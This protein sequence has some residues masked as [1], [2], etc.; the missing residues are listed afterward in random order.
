M[1]SPHS[2][3]AT[4][5]SELRAMLTSE[6]TLE[7]MLEGV[8]DLTI[9][10]LAGADGCGVTFRQGDRVSTVAAAGEPAR[11][12]DEIQYAIG[13]G[14]CLQS[15]QTNKIVHVDDNAVETR[16]APFPERSL[17]E[18]GVHSSLSL[19]IAIEA[20][21]IAVLNVYSR[22]VHAFDDSIRTLA[23][24]FAAQVALVLA[25]RMRLNGHVAMIQQLQTALSSRAVIDQAIGVILAER[26]GTPEAAFDVLRRASQGRNVKLRDI[27]AEL[28]KRAQAG[29]GG[30]PRPQRPS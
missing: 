8:A 20:E 4:G 17:A 19:P 11:A 18:Y 5:L 24:L 12:V 21:A 28:V 26:G 7:Q 3:L 27:A 15:L 6:L 29:P 23:E 1:T 13:D 14:P 10:T 30:R 22:R 16:W 9:R 25:M 2:E